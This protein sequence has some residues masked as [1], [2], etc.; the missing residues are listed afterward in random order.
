VLPALYAFFQAARGRRSQNPA[1]PLLEMPWATS[2]R[3]PNECAG[4]ALAFDFSISHTCDV[5]PRRKI[6]FL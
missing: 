1:T 4:A 5:A 2:I 3:L 6:D